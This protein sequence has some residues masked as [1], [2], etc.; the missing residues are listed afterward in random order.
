MAVEL[1]APPREEGTG[2]RV[3]R[4]YARQIVGRLADMEEAYFASRG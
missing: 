3:Q 2:L 4:E 1:Y